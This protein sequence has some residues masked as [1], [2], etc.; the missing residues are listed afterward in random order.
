MRIVLEKFRHG[1]TVPALGRKAA[2]KNSGMVENFPQ[3]AEK[4]SSGAWNLYCRTA[5]SVVYT[6]WPPAMLP[7][8]SKGSQ[9]YAPKTRGDICW[10]K[11]KGPWHVLGIF[12]PCFEQIC[13]LYS[14]FTAI[15]L[16]PIFHGKLL[17]FF[18]LFWINWPLPQPSEISA[19]SMSWVN[20]GLMFCAIP[21]MFHWNCRLLCMCRSLFSAE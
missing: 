16:P 20:L 8:P 19:F 15:L 2:G 18:C 17:I 6:G 5:A 13:A 7:G 14:L 9:P 21:H 10:P 12:K 11:Y 3:G 4:T 1:G